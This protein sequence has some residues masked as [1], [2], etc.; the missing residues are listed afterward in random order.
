MQG[1]VFAQAASSWQ[2]SNAGS[3]LML[4]GVCLMAWLIALAVK[5]VIVARLDAGLKREMLERGMTAEEIERVVRVHADDRGDKVDLPCACEAVVKWEDDW[6]AALVLQVTD[7]R[8]YIHY[9]GNEM[10]ENE[11]V[12]EDRIRF[13]AGSEL[14]SLVQRLRADRNGVPKKAPM[15]AEL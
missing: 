10:D 3:L 15:E 9:V 6:H 12:G 14:P 13:P 2:W 1:S 11:W 4:A 5:D 8:Y 7:G